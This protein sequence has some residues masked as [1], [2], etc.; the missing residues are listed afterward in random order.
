MLRAGALLPLLAACTPDLLAGANNVRIGVSW[1]GTELDAFRAVLAELQPTPGLEVVPLGDDIDTAFTA[2]GRSAPD[3]VML[4]QAG[5]VRELVERKRLRPLAASLW[6]TGDRYGGG[7]RSPYAPYWERLLF[8]GGTLYGIPFKASTKSM[9]W[10]DRDAVRR[11]GLGDPAAWTIGEWIEHTRELAGGPT[12]ML[13]LAAADGWVL[14]DLFEN[15]LL[16]EAP[17]DYLALTATTERRNWEL[18]SV[19]A[20]L[21]HLGALWSV[22][23]ALP[24]G[25]GHALTRQFPD[26]VREVFDRG[27]AAVVVMPDFAEPVVRRCLTHTGRPP[28][29]VG[30]TWFPRVRPDKPPPR[31]VGGDVAVVSAQAGSAATEVVA[32]LAAPQAP[33]PWIDRYGGFLGPNR[34]TSADY[35]TILEPVAARVRTHEYFDLSDRIG[36]VGGREG[37]WRVLVEFLKEVGDG[38]GPVEPAIDRAVRALNEFESG[39]R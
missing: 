31:I 9:V 6:P 10:Y 3:I 29:S 39:R 37:L 30:A 4:P 7:D 12:R 22:P 8:Q 38:A 11:L 5:R 21:G 27:A 2:A 36:A 32:A 16:G 20:A 15:M 14:T 18:D 26:A 34:Q 17:E 25:I 28:D 23:S 1:S 35:S 19:R 24:G 13:A 33:V